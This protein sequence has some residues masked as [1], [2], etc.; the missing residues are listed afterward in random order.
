VTPYSGGKRVPRPAMSY[1]FLGGGVAVREFKT[2]YE[3]NTFDTTKKHIVESG[4][5]PAYSPPPLLQ[6]PTN[7]VKRSMDN[8]QFFN[9]VR[10]HH[11]T[12]C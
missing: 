4:E 6:R 3:C 8:D 2:E 12:D 1:R 7:D 5:Y 9:Y 10:R 11:P